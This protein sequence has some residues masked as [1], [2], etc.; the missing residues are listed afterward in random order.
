M[1]SPVVAYLCS[2]YCRTSGDIISAGAGSYSAVRIVETKGLRFR[3]E[4]EITPE[5]IAERYNDI[6]D[7][8][9][10]NS[11]SNAQEEFASILGLEGL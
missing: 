3:T 10:A 11:F 9:S 8:E 2:E 5:M 7:M 6:V 1:V 4:Q